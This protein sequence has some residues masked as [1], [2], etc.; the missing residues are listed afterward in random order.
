VK[1]VA[2]AG[3]PQ[4]THAVDIS[5]TLDTAVASVEAHAAYLAGLGLPEGAARGGLEA[6]AKSVGERFDGSPAIAFELIDV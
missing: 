4:P 3:S 6:F 1:H 5:T 2:V